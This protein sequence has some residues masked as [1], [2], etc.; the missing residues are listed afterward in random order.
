MATVAAGSGRGDSGGDS[1]ILFFYDIFFF[2]FLSR[3]LSHS[4]LSV[5]QGLLSTRAAALASHSAVTY[6]CVLPQS[7]R[8]FLVTLGP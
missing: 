7:S 1:D 2:A 6:P 4:P 3:S 8:D 5:S